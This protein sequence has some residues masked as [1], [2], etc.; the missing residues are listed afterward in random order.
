MRLHELKNAPGAR[1]PRK[2]V[3]RG[4]SSGHGK[5]AGRGHKGQHARAGS[6]RR[7]RFEGGQMP[8]IRRLPKVG[9]SS[10]NPVEYQ[11]VNVGQL[12]VFEDG[13]VVDPTVLRERGLARGPARMRIKVLGDGELTKA[14]TVR[15]HAFSRSAAAKIAAAGG[16]AETIR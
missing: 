8:L 5:T 15:A 2:R 1:R 4:E 14:L 6:G 16:T 9:F 3:G 12:E 10:P 7:L 13:A 11:P